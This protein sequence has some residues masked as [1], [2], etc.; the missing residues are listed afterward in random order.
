MCI[1]QLQLKIKSIERKELV[2]FGPW[3]GPL[4]VSQSIRYQSIYH[5][6]YLS[7]LNIFEL[8]KACA[9]QSVPLA[10]FQNA[11]PRLSI[12]KPVACNPR[13]IHVQIYA[14]CGTYFQFYNLNRWIS[15]LCVFRFLFLLRVIPL[16]LTNF[17]RN[18]ILINAE[19][20]KA[21]SRRSQRSKYH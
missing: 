21:K 16:H 13:E 2:R 15:V 6:S 12:T 10:Q 14:Y 1:K 18:D 7:V 8:R 5:F 3:K 19:P 11:V 20:R 9:F 17:Q 4:K